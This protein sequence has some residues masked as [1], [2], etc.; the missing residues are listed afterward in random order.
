MIYYVKEGIPRQPGS[1]P[2][3]SGRKDNFRD[4]GRAVATIPPPA[5]DCASGVTS[6]AS[7]T[8]ELNKGSCA[9]LRFGA[10]SFC[11]RFPFLHRSRPSHYYSQLYEGHQYTNSSN[12]LS[13][14][15]CFN[16]KSYFKELRR[17]L[18]SLRAGAQK[19]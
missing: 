17:L 5:S 13:L 19:A 2:R 4:K 6:C 15:S 18:A 7:P 11:W 16:F 3:K 8:L 14:S 10:C 1:M 9:G 12:Y